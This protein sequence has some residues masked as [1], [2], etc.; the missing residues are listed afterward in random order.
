MHLLSLI[1]VTL[2]LIHQTQA[3]IKRKTV[4]GLQSDRPPL[5]VIAANR[6]LPLLQICQRFGLGEWDLGSME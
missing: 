5:A 1:N 3:A 6:K 2:V 4:A